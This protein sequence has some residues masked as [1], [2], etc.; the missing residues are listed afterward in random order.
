MYIHP[1][2]SLPTF[3][4]C[5]LPISPPLPTS[6]SFLLLKRNCYDVNSAQSQ[7]QDKVGSRFHILVHHWRKLGQEPQTTGSYRGH[8]GGLLTGLLLTACSACFLIESRTI[9][10]ISSSMALHSGLSPCP[11][12]CFN[13]IHCRLAYSHF[14]WRDFLNWGSLFS[15]DYSL[16][17]HKTCQHT[18]H[19]QFM[20]HIYSWV[21]GLPLEHSQACQEPH[22]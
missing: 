11:H 17:W 16:C 4:F 21:W 10:S 22:S 6:Q 15:D 14:L 7:L 13:K 18:N 5:I 3:L 2:H 1:P 12:C 19:G 20:L 9:S 8:E